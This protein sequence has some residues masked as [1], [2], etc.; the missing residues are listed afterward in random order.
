MSASVV[1]S[2]FIG[3][4]VGSVLMMIASMIIQDGECRRCGRNRHRYGGIR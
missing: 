1:G 3:F 2:F 4:A